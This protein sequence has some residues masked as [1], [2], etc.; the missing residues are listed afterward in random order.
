MVLG[1]VA[2]AGL[3]SIGGFV[4]I[5]KVYC[6]LGPISNN[7]EIHFLNNQLW[8]LVD[9]F[10]LNSRNVYGFVNGRILMKCARGL[11]RLGVD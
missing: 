4:P 10:M 6:L 2:L 3:S 11:V 9:R 5:L 7:G 1:C 8:F